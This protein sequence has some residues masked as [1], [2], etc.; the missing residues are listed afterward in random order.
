MAFTNAHRSPQE[1]EAR[2][3]HLAAMRRKWQRNPPRSEKKVITKEQTITVR[4]VI[5]PKAWQP[6]ELA[7]AIR[8]AAKIASEE[9]TPNPLLIEA[10]EL[11]ASYFDDL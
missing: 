3:A 7:H 5:K 11:A 2:E 10:L 1:R 4:Q 8:I 6:R 9:R